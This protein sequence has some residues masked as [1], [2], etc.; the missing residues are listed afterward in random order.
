[1]ALSKM[2]ITASQ[3]ILGAYYSRN[4]YILKCLTQIS[5]Q[6]NHIDVPKRLFSV[7]LGQIRSVSYSNWRSPVQIYISIGSNMITDY[8]SLKIRYECLDE[9]PTV[10]NNLCLYI[11]GLKTKHCSHDRDIIFFSRVQ[12]FVIF[13]TSFLRK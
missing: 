1:M 2:C 6:K 3:Y 5:Y 10:M 4:I 11:V 9:H 12:F 8:F 7:T 13:S